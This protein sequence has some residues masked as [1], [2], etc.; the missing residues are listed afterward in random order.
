MLHKARLLATRLDAA[1]S[2]Q[3]PQYL[4]HDEFARKRQDR[5]I[6]SDE[7]Q[8]P[9]ALSVLWHTAMATFIREPVGEEDGMMKGVGL[10]RADRVEKEDGKDEA[11]R[12]DP[13]ATKQRSSLDALEDLLPLSW[14]M[15]VAVDG[16]SGRGV[17]AQR[18]T[19]LSGAIGPV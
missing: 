12:Y 11:E 9:K 3:G 4:L 10:G 17:G 14:S 1:N 5:G 15:R 2:S 18:G 13:G 6:E 19:G 8:I 7:C 16:G